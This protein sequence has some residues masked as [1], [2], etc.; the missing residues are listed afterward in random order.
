MVIGA[1]EITI[2]LPECHTLKEKRQVIKSILARVRNQFE[3]AIAE[4]GENDRW[5][6]AKI[7]VSCVSNDGQHAEEILQHIRRYIEET[8]PD[9]TI[10]EY[11]IEVINW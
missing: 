6:L 11:D 7:G 1:C 8:R 4:V 10:T 2:H 5:Q 9:L 3:V